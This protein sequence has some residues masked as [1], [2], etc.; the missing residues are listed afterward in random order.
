MQETHGVHVSN[1]NLPFTA[2]ARVIA[3][4]VVIGYHKMDFYGIG[5]S[6]GVL[7]I[8]QEAGNFVRRQFLSFLEIGLRRHIGFSGEF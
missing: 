8:K 6:L 2:I 1:S 7:F 4:R 3:A 5:C